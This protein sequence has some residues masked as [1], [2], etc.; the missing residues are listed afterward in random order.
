MAGRFESEE[1]QH[2]IESYFG[3][4]ENPF[5]VT[6]DPRY[7]YDH[8]L[9]MEGLSQLIYG[10][11]AK[12]GMMLLTGEGGTGKTMLL[13][14]LMRHLPTTQFIAASSR[15]LSAYGL[16][17]LTVGELGLSTD[18]NSGLRMM[19]QLEGF[20]ID[21]LKQKRHVA[22][23][24]DEAQELSD[25]ALRGLCDLSNLETDKEKLLQIILVGQPELAQRLTQPA[26]QRIKQ[27][28]AMHY[29]LSPLKTLA[30]VEQ[31][32][33]HRLEV[34]GYIG[35]DIFDGEA[36]LALWA[37]TAGT[38]R[39]INVLCDNTLPIAASAGRKKVAAQMV[40]QAAA[41]LMLERSA[42][43]PT[44]PSV[45]EPA[46]AKPPAEP[47]P[48]QKPETAQARRHETKPAA[49]PAAAPR[50]TESQPTPSREAPAARGA[51]NTEQVNEV[52]APESD[53]ADNLKLKAAMASIR[54]EPP[55]L[56]G[57]EIETPIKPRRPENFGLPQTHKPPISA[58]SDAP[59]V[60]SAPVSAML[61][62]TNPVG[63]G[64]VKDM[65]VPGKFFDYMVHEA[66]EALGPIG[67]FVV[68]EH[69]SG[70]G[71]SRQTFPRK[72]LP[73]LVEAVSGEI[74]NK[75]MRA[76]FE[77]IMRREI[78]GFRTF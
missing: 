59:A 11:Q 73:L 21:Q 19:Q 10:I 75:Q 72:K 74:A 45:I 70:M 26:L 23:L 17:E 15:H 49:E 2:I 57:K 30:D 22:L 43:L 13:R 31:Y 52:G 48:R 42:E 37:Y 77:V 53:N 6:P 28:I 62:D 50:A 34:A 76:N 4:R 36:I 27:R 67:E 71:E 54:L 18:D 61:N 47:A 16:L 46:K 9:Y 38:P 63:V 32:V 8:S 3:F 58:P 39:L 12:K 35:P 60:P 65:G 51:V 14:K 7:F 25:D 55:I 1:N 78:R 41:L 66:T 33:R 5:G 20:L 29:R 44:E 68:H 40:E 56:R 64:T 24:I 69:I